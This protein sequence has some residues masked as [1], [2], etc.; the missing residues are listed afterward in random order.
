MKTL[1][2]LAREAMAREHARIAANTA[3]L[4]SAERERQNEPAPAGEDWRHTGDIEAVNYRKQVRAARAD[5]AARRREWIP[6]YG[7]G[8]SDDEGI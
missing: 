7:T 3:R 6:G 1:G 2:Q 4:D 5:L 8:E